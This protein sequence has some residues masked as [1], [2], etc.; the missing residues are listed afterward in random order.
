[1]LIL[2]PVFRVVKGREAAVVGMLHRV[3]RLRL[4]IALR[5]SAFWQRATVDADIARGVRIDRGVRVTVRARSVSRIRIGPGCSL[6]ERLSVALD[7]GFLWLGERVDLRRDVMLSVAGTLRLE[8]PN[9]IQVGSSIHC[10]EAITVGRMAVVSEHATIVDSSH[11]HAEPDRWLLD[12]VRTSPITIGTQ[13]W[14]GAKATVGRGARV[15]D[16]AIVSANSLVVGDV[17]AGHLVSGVPAQVVRPVAL[18][19]DPP[20]SSP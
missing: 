8:G 16:Y 13:C 20:V 6:G 17:P 4:L 5:L 3:R 12:N 9:L 14:I 2:T 7:G 10:D 18:G 15:G 11:F 1:M 19:F